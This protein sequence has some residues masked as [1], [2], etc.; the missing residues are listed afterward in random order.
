LFLL[1]G[2]KVLMN[3][4]AEARVY[5]FLFEGTG[6]GSVYIDGGVQAALT[7]TGER[8][9]QSYLDFGDDSQGHGGTCEW[10]YLRWTNEGVFPPK[11]E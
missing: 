10:N 9:K 3:T 2:K 8:T 7:F 4:T 11:S 1:N 5:C 6:D